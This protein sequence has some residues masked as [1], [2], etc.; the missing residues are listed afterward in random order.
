MLNLTFPEGVNQQE[1]IQKYKYKYY[2]QNIESLPKLLTSYTIKPK[3]KHTATVI[4]LHG[5]GDQGQGWGQMFEQ[6]QQEH[7]P[8]VKFLFPNA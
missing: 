1:L 5:L 4:F 3:T 8:H 6:I 7:F 2:N